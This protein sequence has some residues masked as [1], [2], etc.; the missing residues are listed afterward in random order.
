MISFFSYAEKINS[1]SSL[2]EDFPNQTINADVA[3]ESVVRL[4]IFYE[5]LGYT[6][7]IEVVEKQSMLALLVNI[8][9]IVSLF[10]GMSFISIFEIIEFF[11]VAFFYLR[12]N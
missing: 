10:M 9:G 4:H 6:E 1:S 2:R 5:S 12:R 3:R 8:G 7:S 11:I